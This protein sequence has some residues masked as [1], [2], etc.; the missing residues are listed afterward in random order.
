MIPLVQQIM[1]AC[2]EVFHPP[3]THPE[4]RSTVVC[5]LS[6][7]AQVRSAA[8]LRDHAPAAR[9]MAHRSGPQ[10]RSQASRINL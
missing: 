5:Q 8:W 3:N 10:V 2:V 1:Q 6:P 9:S 4:G 7:S